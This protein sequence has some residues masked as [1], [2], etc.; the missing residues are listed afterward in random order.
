MIA[1]ALSCNPSILIADEPTTALDVTIQAQIL[2]RIRELREETERGGDPRDPRPRRG[3]RHRRPDR[4]DVRRAG[5]SSRGRS[6]RSSTTPSIPTPGGCSARSPGSTG[7]APSACRRSRGCRPRWPTGPR[8]ATSG[9]AA[10]TSSRVHQ[11]PAAR[12]PPV[13]EAPTTGIAAGSRSRRSASGARSGPGEIGLRAK[14]GAGGMSVETGAP[15]TAE[16]SP[17]AA[18]PLVEVDHLRGLLSDQEGLLIEREVARVHAVNDITL[19][20]AEGETLGPRGGVRLRQDDDLAGHHAPDRRDRRVDPIP[21]RRDHQGRPQGDGADYAAACRWSSRTRSP[22]S[23]RASAWARS[24]ACRWAARHRAQ[25]GRGAG[26]RAA[27]QG[28]AVTRAR[29]PLPAR[30]LRAASASA[31]AWRAPWRSSRG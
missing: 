21:R 7:R 9:P 11:G 27:R 24:S 30:V 12:G 31:S 15:A 14:E 3:G 5:S 26:P 16:D 28:R 20:I 1:M 22:R 18:S 25:R 4:G 13:D 23:T 17:G 19:S 2:E 8:A 6:T 10:R 29:Q